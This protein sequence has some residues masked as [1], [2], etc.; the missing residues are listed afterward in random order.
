MQVKRKMRPAAKITIMLLVVG[1]VFWAVN[2]FII[3]GDGFNKETKDGEV[4]VNSNQTILPDAPKDQQGHNVVFAGIP[5]NQPANV[6]STQ[7]NMKIMAWN[8]QMGLIY[9]NGGKRTTKG[10]LMEKNGVNLNIERL[11]DCGQMQAE[12]I[13]FASEYKKNPTSATGTHFIAIMG[14]GAP[15]WLAGANEQLS[16][17][18][19]DYKA[20]I[21]FSCGR[22]LG[23]DQFMAPPSVKQNPQNA[24]GMTCATVLRDG[25]WNIVIKWAADNGIPVNTDETTYN[26]EAINFIA[27]SENTDA[28]IKYN[29]G[30]TETRDVVKVTSDG[31]TV[32]TGKRQT[33]KVDMISVWTPADVI[34]AEGKGGLVRIVSTK[35]Y[36]AQMPNAVIGIKKWNAD[37]RTEVENMILAISQGGDQVKTFDEALNKAGELSAEVYGEENGAYWVKYYKGA[38]MIDKVDGNSI[39]ELGGSRVN[40]LADNLELFGLGNNKV[41]TYASVYKVFGDIA[42]S[43]YPEYVPSY[44]SI[45]EVLNLS[46]IQNVANRTNT[47]AGADET[48]YNNNSSEITNVTSKRAWSIEFETGSANF[49]QKTLKT[50]AELH[51]QLVIAQGLQ[52]SIEG[53]TD[54]TGSDEVNIPLSQKRA[55]AV[56]N[57]LQNLSPTN[58]PDSRFV[59]VVGKGSTE[60]LPGGTNSQNRRVEIV[61]GN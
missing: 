41:N 40:N 3:S 19:S 57:W 30:Y 15:S 10:S 59:S 51:D 9:A 47:F 61:L 24:R 44:P 55:E 4:V 38:K 45:D 34:A 32:K 23:E 58:Y 13:S 33:V 14:D 5:S 43:L 46:Y 50:M 35:E 49:T 20:E 54:A 6:N 1:V 48:K 21:I 52:I 37:H 17:L 60:P 31:K 7:I 12:L 53:H 29:T 22:S 2:T 26:P 16:R 18:G 28:S 8:S 11:D 25:D 36:S 27:A 39:V 42:S 56:K